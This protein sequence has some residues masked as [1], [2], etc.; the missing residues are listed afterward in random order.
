MLAGHTLRRDNRNPIYTCNPQLFVPSW[1]T[2]PRK[3]IAQEQAQ[4]IRHK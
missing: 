3:D 2:I 4:Q 1:F